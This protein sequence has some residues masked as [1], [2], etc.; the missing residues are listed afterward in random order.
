[1]QDPYASEMTPEQRFINEN[2]ERTSS[3][4]PPQLPYTT[5]GTSPVTGKEEGLLVTAS[6]YLKDGSEKA[7]AIEEMVWKKINGGSES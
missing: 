1:M 4:P 3:D 5:N 6:K 7:I 2:A